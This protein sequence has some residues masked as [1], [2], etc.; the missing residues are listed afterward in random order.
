MASSDEDLERSYVWNIP[1]GNNPRFF[2][3]IL[4]HPDSAE[5]QGVVSIIPEEVFG[6]NICDI[7]GTGYNTDHPQEEENPDEVRHGMIPR[8]YFHGTNAHIKKVTPRSQASL[9]RF[10][11][12]KFPGIN[13]SVEAD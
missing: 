10:D 9:D 8:S 11:T 1:P 6:F 7:P 2:N 5:H 12:T 13:N 3:T 4:N